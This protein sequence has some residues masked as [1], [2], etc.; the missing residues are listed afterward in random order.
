MAISVIAVHQNQT[1]P[2]SLAVG[3]MKILS[4]IVECVFRGDPSG[5]ISRDTL[6]FSVGPVNFP[7]STIP[8]VASCTVSPASIAF[9]GQVTNALW[10]V[11]G[12][13]VPAF[14]NI[15]RGTGTA[16]LQVVANLAVRGANGLILRVNYTVFYTPS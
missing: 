3:G 14:V 9:D 4:G 16:Q 2:P 13:A 8:P 1:I 7:G 6:T 11:D 15:D 12:A 5:A 10:A